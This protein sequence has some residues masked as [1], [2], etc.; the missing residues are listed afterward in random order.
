MPEIG[1]RLNTNKK[2]TFTLK[3]EDGTNIDLYVKEE[4]ARNGTIMTVAE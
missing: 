2:L 1:F 4:V 3:G